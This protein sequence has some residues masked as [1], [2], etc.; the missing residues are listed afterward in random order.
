MKSLG[1]IAAS[2]SEG[3][4]TFRELIPSP[5]SVCA[6]DDGDGV[7]ARNVRKHSDIDAAVCPRKFHWILSPRKL[8][9]LNVTCNI[10]CT[11]RTADRSTV[12]QAMGRTVQ[13]GEWALAW[14]LAINYR[15]FAV[16][17]EGPWSLYFTTATIYHLSFYVMMYKT[18]WQKRKKGRSFIREYTWIYI[19]THEYTW[20]HMNTHIYTWIYMNIHGYTWKYMNI[21]G[22]TWIYTNIH[23]YTWIYMNI[24]GYT[25]IYMNMHGYAWIYMDIHEYTWIYMNIHEYTWIYMNTHEYTW[26]HMSIHGY[27]WIYMDTHGY[28]WIYM[29][30]H[31]YTWKYMNIQGYTIQA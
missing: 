9:V 5:T 27:T 15:L 1:Q 19:N 10:T 30:I 21:H 31:E 16:M 18:A 11:P 17:F 29:N 14:K 7:S 28:T 2:R 13:T 26:I 6:G 25:W 23:E 24:H 22:Y 3:F 20:I 12:I 4:T 8:Q